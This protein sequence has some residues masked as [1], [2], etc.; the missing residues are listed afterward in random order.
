MN[1]IEKTVNNSLG[2]FTELSQPG[3]MRR[4][5][6]ISFDAYHVHNQH[7]SDNYIMIITVKNG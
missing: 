3:K 1:T 2:K 6:Q 4:T 5:K 7:G